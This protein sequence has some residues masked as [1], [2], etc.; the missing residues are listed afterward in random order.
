MSEELPPS[1]GY[2]FVFMLRL[3]AQLAAVPVVVLVAK[4][5]R[6]TR[7]AVAQ[8]GADKLLVD[9]FTRGALVRTVSGLVNRNCRTQV[10]KV[11]AAAAASADEYI[12]ALQRNC[13]KA[14]SSGKPIPY[15]AVSDACGPLVEA[16][17][18]DDSSGD[19]LQA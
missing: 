5:D 17:G 18:N 16:V 1:G 14:S 9:P 13:R 11:T 15:R 12:G 10:E 8:C 7:D 4:N 6:P 2:D 3:D 19:I